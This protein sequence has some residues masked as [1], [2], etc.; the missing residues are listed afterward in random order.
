MLPG[1][2]AGRIGEGLGMLVCLVVLV[3]VATRMGGW[4]DGG[5]SWYACL[6]G[7]F[8]GSRS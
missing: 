1:W 4:Q 5:G 8:D 6:S 2:E 7:C 3:L